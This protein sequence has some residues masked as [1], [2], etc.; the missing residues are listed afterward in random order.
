M[1]FVTGFET[2]FSNVFKWRNLFINNYASFIP[3]SQGY[4]KSS[5]LYYW[6]IE[7]GRIVQNR[8]KPFKYSLTINQL[9]FTVEA[10]KGPPSEDKSFLSPGS[11]ISG[12][13]IFSRFSGTDIPDIPPEDSVSI[14]TKTTSNSVFYLN[15]RRTVGKSKMGA[16]GIELTLIKRR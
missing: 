7:K 2:R 13:K 12:H 14:K 9:L 3:L 1:V 5:I 11:R 16:D 15:L 6:T 4:N 8:W 10:V